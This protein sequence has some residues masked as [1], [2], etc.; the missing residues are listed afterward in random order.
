MHPRLQAGRGPGGEH[1]SRLVPAERAPLA[2]H[3]H[4]ARVRRARVQHRA[5]DQV[6]VGGQVPV[7]LRRDHVRA[8][9]GHFRGEL[10]G[11]GDAACL[12]GHGEAVAGLALERGR[13]L[14]EQFAGQRRR[15]ARSWSS[16]AALVAATV[17]RMPPA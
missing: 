10:G 17:E 11:Q 12:V 15:F 1:G 3:V 5:A 13:A 16:V 9:V 14:E 6:H 8:Q 4:P 7:E 2:E